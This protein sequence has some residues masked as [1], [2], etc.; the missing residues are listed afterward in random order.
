MKQR[1]ILITATTLFVITGTLLLMGGSGLPFLQKGTE[2]KTTVTMTSN[3]SPAEGIS[4]SAVS[5]P[6]DAQVQQIVPPAA[7]TAG[8]PTRL[9]IPKIKADAHIQYVGT[10]AAGQMQ[11][12]SNGTDVA[13]FKDGTRPGEAGNAVLAGHLDTFT[14]RFGV[15]ANLSKLNVG[16]DVYVTDDKNVVRHFRVI[17]KAVYG[18]RDAPI[19]E[20]FG[21]TSVSRVNMITCY[22]K[23]D[24]KAH[25]Y[26]QR[27][28]V[29]TELV[30]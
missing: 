17:R 21:S 8:Q 22:G 7:P 27:L 10:N 29:Y 23:W 19:E 9:K 4:K 2:A 16:D 20:I 28:V 15:F 25:T 1:T 14:S 24:K 3:I 6:V 11:T 13:W 26:S 12:P 5:K 18:Y 30:P